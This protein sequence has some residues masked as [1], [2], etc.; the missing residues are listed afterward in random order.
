MAEDSVGD[1]LCLS[2]HLGDRSFCVEEV[3]LD[4]EH[5]VQGIV[6]ESGGEGLSKDGEFSVVS[7]VS[8]DL[9]IHAFG[10]LLVDNGEDCLLV[11]LLVGTGCNCESAYADDDKQDEY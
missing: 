11:A 7:V 4:S 3:V 8:F 2:V 6:A 10:D 5:A 9:G 1:R